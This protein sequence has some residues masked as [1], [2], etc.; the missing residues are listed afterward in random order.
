MLRQWH[1]HTRTHAQTHTHTHI[2][3]GWCI[4]RR[5]LK[6]TTV[7]AFVVVVVV[8]PNFAHLSILNIITLCKYKYCIA[9]LR[10]CKVT[11]SK[12]SKTC[13]KWWK[14]WYNFNLIFFSPRHKRVIKVCTKNHICMAYFSRVLKERR[15]LF[16]WDWF[17]RII[18]RCKRHF[19]GFFLYF[20]C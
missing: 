7:R 12:I 13:A 11:Q 4:L 15:Y 2:T 8:L 18:F 3:F 17:V 19:T 14:S 1:T 10:H 9:I 6:A 16:C 5:Q 20:N